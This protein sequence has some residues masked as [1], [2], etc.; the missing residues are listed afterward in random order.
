MAGIYTY[1]E[2]AQEGGRLSERREGGRWGEE[3][4]EG[5]RYER[6]EGEVSKRREGGSWW[7]EEAG[8][9]YIYMRRRR[10]G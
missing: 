9:R 8:G 7:V 3:G 6:E 5:G 4:R 2:V 1:E 10:G